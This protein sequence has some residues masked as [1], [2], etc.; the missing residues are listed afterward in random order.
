MDVSTSTTSSFQRESWLEQTPLL[1][2]LPTSLVHY[3]AGCMVERRLSDGEILFW[4]RDPGDFIGLVID[5][6]IYHMFFTQ[7]GRELIVA[8]SAPGQPIGMSALVCQSPY[9]TTACASGVTRVLLLP[10]HHFHVLLKEKIFVHRLLALMGQQLTAYLDLLETLCLYPLETRLA[11]YL[12]T[13]R[14]PA[15][16]GEAASVVKLPAHQGL[17][18]AMINV[19]R[20]KLNVQLQR[21]KRQGLIHVQGRYLHI[22]DFAQLCHRLPIPHRC[23]QIMVCSTS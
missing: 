23:P 17:L 18:A 16:A 12:L 5:G 20:P 19:S 6:L 14:Q 15:P 4:Q 9:P 11:R 8:H 13:N 21:W 22:D 2:G 1:R 10:R 7:D 3:I